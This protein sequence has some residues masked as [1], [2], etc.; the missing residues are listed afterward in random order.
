MDVFNRFYQENRHRLFAYLMR[1]TGNYHQACDI[2][3]ESFTRYLE[4]YGPKECKGAL[5]YTI[6]RNA[7]FDDNRK[8]ARQVAFDIEPR[9]PGP[10]PETD[11]MVR[12]EYRRVLAA[13]QRLAVGERELLALV[14]GGTLSYQQIA[15]LV[16][17]SVANVKVKVHRARLNLRKLLQQEMNDAV[18]DQHVHR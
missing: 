14:V 17:I 8:Q 2:L 9:E 15:L 13:M 11:V 6:A 10:D 18:L 3:Q 4:H 1:M 5:L 12:E 7:L 16:G